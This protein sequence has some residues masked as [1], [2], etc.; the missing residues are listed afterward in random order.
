MSLKVTVLI[1]SA[2][3]LLATSCSTES[4]VPAGSSSPDSSA[5]PEGS[6]SPDSSA[7]PEASAS[8]TV[9]TGTTI[10]ASTGVTLEEM[11]AY[12]ACFKASGSTGASLATGLDSRIVLAENFIK[13]GTP[14]FAQG[15]LDLAYTS[16]KE[17]QA[18]YD[19]D[20]I[21]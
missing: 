18:K 16:G 5:S 9:N 14:E 21:K 1:I 19:I 8:P 4:N 3:L 15:Q 10:G 17:L 20:C 13:N 6:S 7:S 2:T 12:S 11:K